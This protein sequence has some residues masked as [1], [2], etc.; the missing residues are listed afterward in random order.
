MVDR[1]GTGHV[2]Q[3]PPMKAWPG[4]AERRGMDC[5]RVALLLA[6][7]APLGDVDQAKMEPG[8]ADRAP[9][10][11]PRVDEPGVEGDL[12]ELC[13]PPRRSPPPGPAGDEQQQ[14]LP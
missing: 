3:R 12:Q 14:D 10:E 13:L 7:R 9:L 6:G 1:F 2:P 11:P 8:G 4:G 5:V